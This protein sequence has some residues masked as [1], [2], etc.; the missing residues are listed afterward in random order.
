MGQ[1]TEAGFRA[2]QFET[3]NGRQFQLGKLQLPEPRVGLRKQQAKVSGGCGFEFE[4][5]RRAAVDESAH[6]SEPTAILGNL[7]HTLETLRDTHGLQLELAGS[8]RLSEFQLEI[9]W[10]ARRGR[11]QCDARGGIPVEQ[12]RSIKT[13][14]HAGCD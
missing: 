13:S 8:E 4:R 9:L 3:E 14:R 11:G 12:V 7:Q 10:R 1:W 6:I 2:S 5:Q